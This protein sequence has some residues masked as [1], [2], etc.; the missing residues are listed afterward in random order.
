MCLGTILHSRGKFAEIP[1]QFS[2]V[3]PRLDDDGN[4]LSLKGGSL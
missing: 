3:C 4:I 2:S 1:P